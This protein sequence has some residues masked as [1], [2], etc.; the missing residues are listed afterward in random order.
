MKIENI[1]QAVIEAKRFLEAVEKYQQDG[2][3]SWDSK[4][5]ANIKRKSMDLTRQLAKMRQER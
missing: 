2:C 3:K 4:N 1:E 5:T